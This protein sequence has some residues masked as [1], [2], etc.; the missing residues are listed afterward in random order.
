MISD[1]SMLGEKTWNQIKFAVLK[2]DT[3]RNEPWFKELKDFQ[4]TLLDDLKQV[5]LDVGHD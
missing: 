4:K 5:Q 3:Y 2:D 1:E